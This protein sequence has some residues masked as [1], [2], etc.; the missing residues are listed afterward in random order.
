[1]RK[2]QYRAAILTSPALFIKTRPI[3]PD[4]SDILKDPAIL[5]TSLLQGGVMTSIVLNSLTLKSFSLNKEA[6]FPLG[7][8]KTIEVKQGKTV[9]PYFGMGRRRVCTFYGGEGIVTLGKISYRIRK[10]FVAVLMPDC[11]FSVT[12]T[13]R[14]RVIFLLYSAPE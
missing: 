7:I 13:G 5:L 1:M 12:P 9:V 2:E 10:G 11:E 8:P 4:H 6:G 3:L 14:K